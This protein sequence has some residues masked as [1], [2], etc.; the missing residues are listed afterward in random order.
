MP[1]RAA[2]PSARSA[3]RLGA[4]V[5]VGDVDPLA[6]RGEQGP[7]D[8]RGFSM[9]PAG[10]RIEHQD[11]RRVGRLGFDQHGQFEVRAV[12]SPPTLAKH[13]R[14]LPGRGTFDPHVGVAPDAFTRRFAATAWAVVGTVSRT[15]FGQNSGAVLLADVHP[16]GERDGAIDDHDLAM[17]AK[18]SHPRPAQ[19]SEEAHRIEQPE[20]DTQPLEDLPELFSRLHRPEGIGDHP[21]LDATRDGAAQRRD[22]QAADAVVLEDVAL[23]EDLV[24][25][26]IDRSEHCRR[27]Q[28]AVGE[29]LD[30]RRGENR[31]LV[32]AVKQLRQ[33]RIAHA[34]GKYARGPLHPAARRRVAMRPRSRNR[35]PATAAHPLGGGSGGVDA[36][37]DASDRSDRSDRAGE[38]G[39]SAAMPRFGEFARRADQRAE[40]PSAQPQ[41]R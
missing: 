32:D 39:G 29:D 18:E 4:K 22:D 10:A 13:D 2:R 25:R 20:H 23:E 36:G 9:P 21:H 35:P 33:A 41:A 34:V 7:E 14:E 31:R 6:R 1:R 37:S 28:V 8:Q 27:R 24:A 12:G 38:A 19:R 17:V 26:R 11:S 30:A 3:A 5:G 15:P 16:A 40:A